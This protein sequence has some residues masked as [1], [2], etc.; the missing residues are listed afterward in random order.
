MAHL[1]CPNHLF[2]EPA[3]LPVGGRELDRDRVVWLPKIM[4]LP[5]SLPWMESVDAKMARAKEHLDTLYA[6]AV[7]FFESTKRNFILKSNGR[8]RGSSTTLRIQSRRSASVCCWASAFS[9]SDR[10]SIT[11]FAASYGRRIHTR[12]AKV[13]NSRFVP[14]RSSGK[15]IG[16]NT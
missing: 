9:T 13:P 7:V 10:R 1:I 11:L 5:D 8:R 4:P 3:P 14:P 12:R 16:R 2:W 6:E 15:R